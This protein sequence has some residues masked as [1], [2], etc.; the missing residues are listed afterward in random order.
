MRP[1]I[2]IAG[3]FA[4]L[5]QAAEPIS[6]DVHRDANCGC[7][8]AWISHLQDNGFS[9]NDHVES[10]MS[11][12]KQRL[13]VPPR[14]ASCHT[15]VIDGKFVEGHVPAADILK[16][17]QQPDLLGAAVPGMPAGSPGMEM[18]DRQQAYQVIGLDQQ[19]KERVLG[20]YPGN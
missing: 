13:G 15:G 7:C 8:K 10:D 9:I 5:A 11:A 17:R 19:G 3:L 6:I 4:G 14:L 20:D 12:V 18:G 16:L 2:L 1:L